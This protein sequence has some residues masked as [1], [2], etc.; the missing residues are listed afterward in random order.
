MNSYVLDPAHIAPFRSDANSNGH[1]PMANH[2][3]MGTPRS[4]NLGGAVFGGNGQL[5]AMQMNQI[6]TTYGSQP[7]WSMGDGDRGA[8]PLRT[9]GQRYNNRTAGPYDRNGGK[10]GRD[11]R[12]G[13]NNSGRLS[14]PRGGK[15]MHA[16]FSDGGAGP[17]EAVQGRTM[18]SYEDLDAASASNTTAALDY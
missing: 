17:R 18:K 7:Q 8:G 10:N 4:F 6:L 3:Q 5:N 1:F 14:P 12:W 16:R 13:S 15:P 9:G 2:G 11:A